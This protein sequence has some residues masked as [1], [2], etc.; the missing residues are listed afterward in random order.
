[1]YA[2]A[3]LGLV[4]PYQAKRLAWGTSPNWPVLCWVG[5]KT[6]TQSMYPVVKSVRSLK[7][8]EVAWHDSADYS[9]NESQ[10]WQRYNVLV[11]RHAVKVCGTVA[12]L[13]ACAFTTLEDCTD[14]R[15]DWSRFC[16]DVV[17]QVETVRTDCWHCLISRM[18]GVFYPVFGK[19]K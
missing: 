10:I 5:R 6:T 16:Q 19:V 3:V 13:L 15:L 9:D 8:V 1:M 12:V 17:N 4:F 14:D 7:V 18:H 11:V 2:F